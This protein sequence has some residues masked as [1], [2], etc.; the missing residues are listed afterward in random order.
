M[1]AIDYAPI[2][3][4]LVDPEGKFHRIN[5]A[6]CEMTGYSKEELSE[7]NF[8]DITHPDD[9]DIGLTAKQHLIE[10]RIDR[11]SLEKR[12]L[13]KDASVIDVYLTTSLHRDSKGSPKYFFSLVQD[14]NARKL[15][16][17]LNHLCPNLKTLFMSGYTAD[18]IAHHGV[19]EEGV[20][21]INKP[22][23]KKDLAVRVRQV[24]DNANR[25]LIQGRYT[26]EQH[27][28]KH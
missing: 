17:H 1:N 19:L 2:E 28:E 18:A 27:K 16:D 10:G 22:F 25:Q 24:L 11:A 20:C 5:E 23:S 9:Y 21:L 7:M 13:K 26:D 12:Y 4:V 3:I 8:Q 14:I 6:F 15:A